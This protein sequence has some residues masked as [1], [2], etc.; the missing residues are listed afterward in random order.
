M[1]AKYPKMGIKLMW[2]FLFIHAGLPNVF[3]LGKFKCNPDMRDMLCPEESTCRTGKGSMET[4][5]YVLSWQPS[6][7]NGR[8][9]VLNL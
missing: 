5:E 6:H 4:K 8:A 2:V 7:H 3:V 9:L 1:A